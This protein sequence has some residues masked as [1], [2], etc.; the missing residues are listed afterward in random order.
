[1]TPRVS[2]RNLVDDILGAGERLLAAARRFARLA[3]DRAVA[4]MHLDPHHMAIG[5]AKRG[6][7]RIVQHV[8]PCAAS[9]MPRR[10]GDAVWR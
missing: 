10:I 6:D 5:G 4:E 9:A 8:E 2:L 7:V 3:F 1:M